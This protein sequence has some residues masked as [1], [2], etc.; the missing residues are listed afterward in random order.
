MKWQELSTT[1][2]Y[3]TAM[4]IKRALQGGDVQEAITGIEELIEAL[5]RSDRRALRSQLIRL[6]MH[7]IKWKAQPERR[8]LSWSASIRNAREEILDIQEETPSLTNEAIKEMWSKCFI[9]AK[10]EAEGEMNQKISIT[11]LSWEEVFE[12]SYEI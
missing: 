7:I 4:A 12:E 11:E 8:S 2:H 6:M 9:A 10:R 3:Q 5:S 1:S